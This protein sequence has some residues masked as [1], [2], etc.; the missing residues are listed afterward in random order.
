MTPL[1]LGNDIGGS[2]RNPAFCCGIASLKPSFG[3]IPQASSLEPASPGLAAQWMA[4]QG[5]MARGVGD[6]RTALSVLAGPHPRDPLSFPAPL[7]GPTPPAPTRV[8]LVPEP[9]GGTMDAGL[10]DAVRTAGR[11][12]RDAG[13]EVQEVTPPMVE[14]AVTLW[15]RW[16]AGELHLQR[17]ILASIMSKDAAGFLEAYLDMFG[18]L[19]LL[20]HATVIVERHVVAR[21]WSEFFAEYPLIVGPTWCQPQFEHGFDV[22]KPE[23]V[24][25]IL[26]L[27]RFVTPMNL[28]GLPVVCV[29][30]GLA[31]GLPTG[32]Q[33]I[34]DRF[35]EDL[36]LDAGEAIEKRL[37]VLAP[38]DP[39]A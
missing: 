37:G 15:G 4:V 16:L 7:T 29:P 27:M 12:L 19:T 25:D 22:E 26:D 10:A 14:E 9:P 28:L 23:R 24:R 11:A 17:E 2:L 30:T 38:V 18:P 34:G 31:N 6:L 36:C 32:V 1:G 13:Y 3:R 21:A 33:V 5:P 35:R 39:R 20:E 8:A